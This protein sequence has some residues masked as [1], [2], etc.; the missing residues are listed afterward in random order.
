MY[1]DFVNNCNGLVNQLRNDYHLVFV[2]G[3][4][5]QVRL[6]I[7]ANKDTAFLRANEI[8]YMVNKAAAKTAKVISMNNEVA[9]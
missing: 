8:T 2:G 5:D 1:R 7:L 3:D 9:N 4:Y 6:T